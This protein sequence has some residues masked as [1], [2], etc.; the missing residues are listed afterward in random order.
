MI[1]AIEMILDYVGEWSPF[2]IDALGLV[3]LLGAEEVDSAV[4][5]L[6]ENPWVEYLP[7]LAAFVVAGNRYV[8]PKSGYV[9]YNISDGIMATDVAGW[10]SRWLGA[11]QLKWNTTTFTWNVRRR[12][13]NVWRRRIPALVIGFLF[14]AGLIVLSIL[15]N[16]WFGFANAVAMTASVYVRSYLVQQ[17]QNALDHK[18]SNLEERDRE[19]VKTLCLLS[20]GRAVTLLAPRGMVTGC[21]LTTPQPW[22]NSLYNAVRSVGWLAFGCHVICIGQSTLFIQLLTVALILVATIVDVNGFGCDEHQIGRCISVL[23]ENSSIGDDTRTSAYVRLELSS[24]EEAT[25]LAWALLPRPTNQRWWKNYKELKHMRE[26]PPAL[27]SRHNEL[28]HSQSRMN[29]GLKVHKTF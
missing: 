9:L 2:R 23:R 18:A 21:F 25:M 1:P 27:D 14:N 8:Q 17:N 29:M 12:P 5:R 13:R 16:D 3:T 10:L 6:V 28:R 24:E 22:D 7:L 19:L 15:A 26:S 4:G 11:Q 20:N